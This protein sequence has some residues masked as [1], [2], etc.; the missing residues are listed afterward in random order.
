[1]EMYVLL[2][3]WFQNTTIV[4]INILRVFIIYHTRCVLWFGLP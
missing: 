4:D 3:D 1:M 2:D